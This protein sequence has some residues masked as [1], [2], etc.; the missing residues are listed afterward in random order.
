[1]DKYLRDAETHCFAEGHKWD[2]D[3]PEVCDACPECIDAAIKKAYWAGFVAG[4]AS[5]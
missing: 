4:Q 2:E 5:R 3:S 1:M